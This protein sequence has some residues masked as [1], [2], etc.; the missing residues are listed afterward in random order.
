MKVKP[1]YLIGFA[2]SGKSTLLKQLMR[3]FRLSGIDTDK[4]IEKETG[5]TIAEIFARYGETR[6]RELEKNAIRDVSSIYPLIATGGGLPC[7]NNQ[8][9]VLKR[10][11]RWDSANAHLA[12]GSSPHGSRR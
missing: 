11:G 3:S 2:G 7:Y 1:V 10:I 6:F 12:K 5:L 8:M 9:A 4:Y